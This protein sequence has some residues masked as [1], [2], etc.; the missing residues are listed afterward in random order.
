MKIFWF[1]L[2]INIGLF[3]SISSTFLSS[4]RYLKSNL[5]E[6]ENI[7]NYDIANTEEDSAI[8]N[9]QDSKSS[10][11]AN[12]SILNFFEE[13]FNLLSMKKDTFIE[14]NTSNAKITNGAQ[15][16]CFWLEE[17]SLA[18]FDIKELQ[19]PTKNKE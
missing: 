2:I 11:T 5:N 16:R 19:T 1:I 10:K 6:N 9:N 15:V 3:V 12:S 17:T 7:K 4:I 13:T 18:V 8:R 14:K